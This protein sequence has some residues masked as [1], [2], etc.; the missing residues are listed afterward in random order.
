MQVGH[1]C[2]YRY[3]YGYSF[4]LP[5]ISAPMWRFVLYGTGALFD[6]WEWSIGPEGCHP[7]Q[8][9]TVQQPQARFSEATGTLFNTLRPKQNGRHFTNV[10]IKCIFMNENIYIYISIGWNFTEICSHVSIYNI[11]ALVHNGLVPA[12]WQTIIWIGDGQCT[13]AYYRHLS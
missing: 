7:N 8:F 1:I 10:I 5:Y 12:C 9:E 11:P 2:I 13:Y 4:P 3:D 6:L